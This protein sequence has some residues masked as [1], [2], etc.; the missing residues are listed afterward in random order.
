MGPKVG[1]RSLK[2]GQKQVKSKQIPL[3]LDLLLT[4]FRDPKPTSGPTLDVLEYSGIFE[5]SRRTRAT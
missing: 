5:A 1:F 2:G 3:L 4:I